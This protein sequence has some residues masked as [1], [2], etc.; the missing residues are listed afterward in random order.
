MADIKILNYFVKINTKNKIYSTMKF[1]NYFTFEFSDVFK[2]LGQIAASD[3]II[4]IKRQTYII[5]YKQLHY[6]IIVFSYFSIL[7]ILLYN[8]KTAILVA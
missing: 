4:I 8:S 7:I 6:K 1:L 2:S 3:Y 5:I